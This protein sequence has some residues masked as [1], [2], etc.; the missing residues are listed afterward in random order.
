MVTKS[1][2]KNLDTCMSLYYKKNIDSSLEIFSYNAH[3]SSEIIGNLQ[4]F[5]ENVQ[6][7]LSGLR[8]AFGECLEIFRKC[9]EMFGKSSKKSLTQNN[10]WLLVDMNFLFLCST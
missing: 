8:T 6:K 5:S 1:L 4:R 10:M 7:R 3:V 2:K 9:L